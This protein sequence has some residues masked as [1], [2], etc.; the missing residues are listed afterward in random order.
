METILAA[1]AYPGVPGITGPRTGG[2]PLILTIRA[3]PWVG[4]RFSSS[5]QSGNALDVRFRPPCERI[6]DAVP[7]PRSANSSRNFR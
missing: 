6:Y 4:D 5:A 7:F 2:F 1:K 3:L